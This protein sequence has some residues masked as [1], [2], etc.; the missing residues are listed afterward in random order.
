MNDTNGT[1]K[2]VDLGLSVFLLAIKTELI[3]IDRGN[4]REAV[5]VFRPSPDQEQEILSWHQGVAM[6]N[7]QSFWG[8]Y[9]ELKLRLYGRNLNNTENE[10]GTH[11]RTG[12]TD[13]GQP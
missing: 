1:I 5:F 4:P 2:T 3:E 8:A 11:S 10:I 7:A 12:Y 9:R 13:A 6:V